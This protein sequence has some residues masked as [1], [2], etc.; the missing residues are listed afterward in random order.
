MRQIQKISD[1]FTSIPDIVNG[2][3]SLIGPLLA[4]AAIP[5]AFRWPD[6]FKAFSDFSSQVMPSMTASGLSS[7]SSSSSSSASSSTPLVAT[8]RSLFSLLSQFVRDTAMQL[9]E[10]KVSEAKVRATAL[11]LASVRLGAASGWNLKVGQMKAVELAP[12]HFKLGQ[13]GYA[14]GYAD[15]V[16]Q[17]AID[18]DAKMTDL[19][20]REISA[21][22][23]F[24][25]AGVGLLGLTGTSLAYSGHHYLGQP[26]FE[27]YLAALHIVAGGPIA[28]K[29]EIAEVTDAIGGKADLL[30]L[31]CHKSLHPIDESYIL[32]VCSDRVI[33]ENLAAA[34][35]ANAAV[36][37]PI[38][39]AGSLGLSSVESLLDQVSSV[40][41]DEGGSV[42]ALRK[43]CLQA[44]QQ[45]TEAKNDSD[46]GKLA[47]SVRAML[48]S[49]G[50]DIAYCIGL[51]RAMLEEVGTAAR[52]T[53]LRGYFLRS[54]EELHAYDVTQ[55]ATFWRSHVAVVR[56]RDVS[57]QARQIGKTLTAGPLA[58]PVVSSADRDMHAQVIARVSAMALSQAS[59]PSAGPAPQ[60]S[61]Q[62]Q[63]ASAATHLPGPPP[64]AHSRSGSGG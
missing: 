56:A 42:D 48:L 37:L 17:T 30:D 2:T 8:S 64:S 1:P 4:K 53:L 22:S 9:I 20:D 7:S 19:T 34:K 59:P 41:L 13:D 21:A 43:F 33:C 29:R 16:S 55:G 58:L 62:L 45:L 18:W 26:F 52:S 35:L 27:R 54:I 61:L 28:P 24:F 11:N 39:Q 50:A 10:G 5:L 32:I 15:G 47:A 36:R 60:A 23:S 49:Q 12:S 3:A 57:Q 44:K 31:M 51:Y 6:E 40:L 14:T 25:R 63:Q 38:S 46:R